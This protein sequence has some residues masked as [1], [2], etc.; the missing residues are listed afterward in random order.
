MNPFRWL[1]EAAKN[2]VL[3][4]VHDAAELLAADG[5]AFTVRLELPAL[6]NA[7]AVGGGPAAVEDVADGDEPAKPKRKRG[8]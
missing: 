6:A 2:S 3:G 5:H 1:R 7:P 8:G 4:G